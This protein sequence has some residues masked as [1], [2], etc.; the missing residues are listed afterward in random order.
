MLYLIQSVTKPASQAKMPNE[1][2]VWN[3]THIDIMLQ[4][5]SQ[6]ET[7]LEKN[8]SGFFKQLGVDGL[9]IGNVRKIIKVGFDD[10][11]KV[12]HIT[13]AQL[14]EIDGFKEKMA[15][16][17]YQGI[18][19]KVKNASLIEIAAYSNVFGRGFSQKKMELSLKI[20]QILLLVSS[21]NKK[22]EK[23]SKIK[24]LEKKT[25]EAF[26]SHIE[27]F[28]VFLNNCKLQDKLKTRVL[29]MKPINKDHVLYDKTIVMTEF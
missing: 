1:K 19:E 18:Q 8:I 28:K 20:I 27:D 3:D 16:K 6:N 9:A 21:D 24:G 10:V 29:E 26:V 15:E 7:V 12:I 5:K 22:I 2:Y 4:D 23:M 11:C 13:K 14:L 25:A 17:L